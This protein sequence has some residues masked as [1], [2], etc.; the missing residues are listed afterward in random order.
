MTVPVMS[1]N[2]KSVIISQRHHQLDNPD[3]SS[4]ISIEEL[5]ENNLESSYDIAMYEFDKGKLP[6]YEVIRMYPNGYYEKWVH[7]DF[8]LFPD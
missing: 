1:V 8:K 3:N 2:E 4:T 7:S 6:Y 5:Q